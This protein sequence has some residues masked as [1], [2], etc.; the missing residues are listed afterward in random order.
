LIVAAASAVDI[1]T[2]QPLV[3]EV[4][5]AAPKSYPRLLITDADVGP[6]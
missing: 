1:E 5:T 6:R 4:E 2:R 3:L